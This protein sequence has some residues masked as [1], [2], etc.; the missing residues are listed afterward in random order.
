MLKRTLTAALAATG[1]LA[2]GMTMAAPAAQAERC[3]MVAFINQGH[4][5]IMVENVNTQDP[6]FVYSQGVK[7][8]ENSSPGSWESL[9]LIPGGEP[10]GF[11]AFNR[12]G[13][14][15]GDS[16]NFTFYTTDSTG[17]TPYRFKNPWVY[18][19]DLLGFLSAEGHDGVTAETLAVA[20]SLEDN[21]L[22]V[23]FTEGWVN[24]VLAHCSR[25]A[26]VAS[27]APVG[28][29]ADVSTEA[30]LSD[31]SDIVNPDAPADDTSG[32][33]APADDTSGDDAPAGDTSGDDA[34]AGDASGTDDA[35][36]DDAN[37]GPNPV[38]MSNAR[39]ALDTRSK[40]LTTGDHQVVAKH[41]TRVEKM[42]NKVHNRGGVL[43]IHAYGPD[44]DLALARAR[45]V[46]AHL[47]A[48]LAKRG[49]TESSPIW[50]TYA[51]NPEHKKD[52]H[53]TV[54]WHPDTTLPG[55]LPGAK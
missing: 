30:V 11:S 51:G 37:A 22:K 38:V 42:A 10:N 2:G 55:A 16:A 36:S 49:H 13:I 5:D 46:R 53:V 48:Q 9:P 3:L 45:A 15:S 41:H 54:H 28:S 32:D 4:G 29:A 31:D 8:C 20:S 52:V 23:T 1:L 19:S 14:R 43:T 26:E 34:P 35:P 27:E 33:D 6:G 21:E 12:I 39:I 7:D 24:S 50:V 47:E 44:E 18:V 40:T 25:G 17:C